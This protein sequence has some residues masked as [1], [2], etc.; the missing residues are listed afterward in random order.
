MG[1]KSC[2]HFFSNPEILKTQKVD[3]CR[4]FNSLVRSVAPQPLLGTTFTHFSKWVG[5]LVSMEKKG[6]EPDLLP[7]RL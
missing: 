5:W 1:R 6:R 3:H 2:F 7:D 4:P